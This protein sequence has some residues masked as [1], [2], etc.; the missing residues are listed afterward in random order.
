MYQ[1]LNVEFKTSQKTVV[2]VSPFVEG[3]TVYDLEENTSCILE[4]LR[5][6]A[7]GILRNF[8]SIEKIDSN[9]LEQYHVE[10][11]EKISGSSNASVREKVSIK[12]NVP[13]PN[14]DKVIKVLREDEFHICEVSMSFAVPKVGETSFVELKKS[15]YQTLQDEYMILSY[16]DVNGMKFE[17]D[18][19]F[20]VSVSL[21]DHVVRLHFC[22]KYDWQFNSRMKKFDVM[23]FLTKLM[24]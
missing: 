17:Y 3:I 19:N 12:T 4:E 18:D 14:M 10:S 2:E 21:I 1:L 11:T 13:N 7:S 5:K 15:V 22:T 23:D 16:D 6:E 9:D 20:Y 24:K 8:V